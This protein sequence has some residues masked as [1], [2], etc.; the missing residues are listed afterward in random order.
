MVIKISKCKFTNDFKLNVFK[1]W[2]MKLQLKI[3]DYESPCRYW[4]KEYQYQEWCHS[5]YKFQGTHRSHYCC[6]S[7]Q[8]WLVKT[9]TSKQNKVN[10]DQFLFSSLHPSEVFRLARSTGCILLHQENQ[11]N[12]SGHRAA[13][14]KY[15]CS[16]APHS[17]VLHHCTHSPGYHT[18]P[19]SLNSQP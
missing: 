10:G 15:T 1:I 19:G 9:I 5:A 18:K 16:T 3:N 2:I 11:R 6:S 14:D 8:L 13:S 4:H 17:A 12:N 7:K